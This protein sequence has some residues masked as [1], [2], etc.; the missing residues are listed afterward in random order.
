MTTT[1]QQPAATPSAGA[2][3][4][5]RSRAFR[6]IWTATLISNIGMW[7]KDVASGWLMTELSPSPLMVAL[8]QAALTLPIFLLAL[9]AG[10]VA[11]IVDRRRLLVAVQSLIAL[12]AVALA[13]AV[14]ADVMAPWVL[15]ALTF[16]GGVGAAL[17]APAFQA[18]VP[19]LVDK[20]TLRS[21]VALNSM[22]INVARAIGPALGGLVLATAGVAAAYA[23][24]ALST[25]VVV[26]AFLWWRPPL[27]Q[28]AL[29]PES[30]GSAIATGVR[31]AAASPEL[32]AVL[33][34]A[35][36]FFLFASAYWALLPLIARDQ[37]GGGSTYYGFLLTA[38]GA[39]AVTGALSLPHLAKRA[40]PDVLVTVGTLL[41]AS[42]TAV[43]G[44]VPNK[45]LA[46]IL[47]FLAG[48]AWI[49][50]LTNLNVAA[51]SILPN[52]VR[53]RGLA[54]YLTVFY[55]AM[56]LG[57]AIWGQI[58][59][60]LSL[61]AALVIAAACA[62][63]IG[64]IA[65][66]VRLP[67]GEADLTPSLHWPELAHSAVEDHRGPVL[68]E[69]TYTVPAELRDAF[70]PAAVAFSRRRRRDGAFGWRLLEDPNEP[71]RFLEVFFAA[72]WLEHLRQ[73]SRVTKSDA[74]AQAALAGFHRSATPPEVRHWVGMSHPH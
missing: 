54:I 2:F 42:V 46:P 56:T 32:K 61:S 8:V 29:P 23:L 53:A 59:S 50:V 19:D 71:G 16:L 74:E 20:A 33:L 37:L 43:L 44:L 72:S 52:W 36:V 17:A 25:L 14:V 38:L 41:T 21:A 70:I 69:I 27:R 18:A 26:A 63:V 28:T 12:V 13:L 60:M 30:L 1:Q 51:Q 34:R 67:K 35:G 24:D 39:G 6:V 9:P 66:L 3:A 48:A 64:G 5:F 55:G 62:T 68:I 58:A 65:T 40:S 47:L 4:P 15:L 10:A 7:M 22:G 73:H 57:S 45:A 49:A 31:Y 11:D